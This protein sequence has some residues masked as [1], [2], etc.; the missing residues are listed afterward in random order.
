MQEK[1]AKE[2]LD[3]LADQVEE[4][5]TIVEDELSPEFIHQM[6]NDSVTS[7][8]VQETIVLTCKQLG[9]LGYLQVGPTTAVLKIN[10]TSILNHIKEH[11][12]DFISE[13]KHHISKMLLNH[14]RAKRRGR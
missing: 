2:K 11:V 9:E 12:T 8:L 4:K 10:K 13:V 7:N 1:E 3:D 6:L 5:L 14:V